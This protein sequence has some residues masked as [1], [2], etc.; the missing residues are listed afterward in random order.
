[1]KPTGDRWTLSEKHQLQAFNDW[2][3]SEWIHG[4]APVVQRMAQDRTLS[5]NSMFWEMYRNIGNQIGES[6]TF[7][8]RTCKLHYGVGIRKA[9][10]PEFTEM[11]NTIIKPHPYQ[12]KLL[13][14]DDLRITSTFTKELGSEYIEAIIHAYGERGITVRRPG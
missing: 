11:Y 4:R 5:Q 8:C 6:A 9:V 2:V 13:L 10:D 12:L 3:K 1:M 14:M 7:V